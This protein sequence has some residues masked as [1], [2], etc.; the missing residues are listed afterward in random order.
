MI[1]LRMKHIKCDWSELGVNV[2]QVTFLLCKIMLL[3]NNAKNVI[4][5]LGH[6]HWLTTD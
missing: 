2:D 3:W 1:V 4:N 6:N 5:I